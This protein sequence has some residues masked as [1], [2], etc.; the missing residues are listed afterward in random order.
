[1]KGERQNMVTT[2]NIT[3]FLMQKAVIA[4]GERGRGNYRNVTWEKPA[5]ELKI[6]IVITIIANV[7]IHT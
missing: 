6:L 4:R 3:I 5:V 1:M 2:E 7:K